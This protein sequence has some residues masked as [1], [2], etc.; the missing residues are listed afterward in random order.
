[1]KMMILLIKMVNDDRDDDDAL[2]ELEFNLNQLR[3]VIPELATE[4][5]DADGLVRCRS[6]D[7]QIST[8]VC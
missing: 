2:S 8:I 7:Q 4:D 5:L 1:M 3:K 6:G